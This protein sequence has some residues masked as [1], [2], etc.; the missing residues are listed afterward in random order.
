MKK[1]IREA[2]SR[3]SFFTRGSV[4]LGGA[5]AGGAGLAGCRK[6]DVTQGRV[7]DNKP[8]PGMD[9]DPSMV[10]WRRGDS[11][12]ITMDGAK[13]LRILPSGGVVVI[14]ADG[15]EAVDLPEYGGLAKV[16]AVTEP[17]YDLIEWPDGGFFTANRQDIYFH[18]N[19]DDKEGTIRL[20]LGGNA[21]I[22]NLETDGEFIYVADM[23]NRL[24]WKVSPTGRMI[25]NWGKKDPALNQPGLVVPSPYLEL[26]L[27]PQGQLWGVNPGR[28]TV[29]LYNE[30]FSVERSWGFASAR[31]AGFCGCCNPTHLVALADGTFLTCEKGLPRVK[32]YSEK[33]E[34][35]GLVV[36]PDDFEPGNESIVI[37]ARD[38]DE[39]L[40]L[41]PTGQKIW[42]YLRNA[43]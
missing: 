2:L 26:T 21:F 43:T 13:N 8:G 39:V 17:R 35:I 16:P 7:F 12:D 20:S 15:F 11:V 40:V 18:E 42:R 37:A 28:H 24:F 36:P 32:L 4:L 31:T 3:R 25:G 27:D 22:T 9:Y 34:L 5:V 29:D 14:G 10:K 6:P 23:G 38:A 19:A 41:N 33:G 30:D 1:Q